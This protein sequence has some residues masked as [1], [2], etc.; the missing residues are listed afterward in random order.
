MIEGTKLGRYEIRAKIGAGGMGEVY[1]AQDTKLD[2]KVALKILPADVAAQPDRMKRFVQEAKAASALNHPNIITIHEIDEWGSSATIREGVHFI[3]TEFID[4]ETLRERMRNAP[5]KLAEVLDVAAQIASALSAA[6]A[7]G[8]VH[9]DIKPENVML[10]RDGIVKVL[11]FGLAKLTEPVPPEAVDT[12]AP[13]RTAIKTES[14][15]VM[16]TAIYM[17]PEQAR[18]LQLDARTD[19]FSLGVLIYEMVAGRLPFE[20]SNTNEIVASILCDREP[21]PLARYAG[22]VPAELERIV[23]KALR[24]EREERYQSVKDLLLDLRSLQHRLK[25]EAELERSKPPEVDRAAAAINSDKLSAG[26]SIASASPAGVAAQTA[27][28]GESLTTGSTS[29]RRSV[30]IAIAALVIAAAGFAYFFYFGRVTSAIDSIAVLPLANTS[31]DPNTEYLSDG[32]SEAL[33]NSLTELQQLRVVAR[34]TAFRY[35]GKEIDPQAV[36][37]ELSV[38]AVLMGTVRQ[39]GDTLNIQVDL[40]DATTGAQLWGRE[41]ERKVSDVLSVKQA[42]AREVTEKLRLRLSG[43]DEQRLAKRDM[44]NAEAYQFYLRGRYFWNKRT[45]ESIDKAIQEFQQAI[46][47]DPNYAL[48]YVGLADCYLAR[49]IY[50][51]GSSN[52]HLAKAR[53]A[54]DRALEVNDS[55]SEAHTSSAMVYLSQWR[56]REAGEEFKRAISLNPNNPIAHQWFGAYFQCSGRSDDALRELKRAQELDPLSPIITV[57]VALEYLSKHDSNSAIEQCQR[58]IELDPRIHGAHH[59]L[60][61]AYLQQHRYEEAIAEL[62]KA[63]ELSGR[64]SLNLASLGYCY[65]LAG[66]RAEALAIIRELEERYARGQATGLQLATVYAGLGDKDHAFAWLEKDFQQQTS[67]V[68]SV[69][70]WI[71]FEDIRADADSRHFIAMEFVDGVTLRNKI[72]GEHAELRKLLRFLQH[73]AEGLAKAHAAGIVHRDLKPDNIMIT[74]D[75]HAKILDFGLAKLIERPPMSGADSSEVA[76][77]VM[78]QHSTPGAIMGTVGYM[79]PEQAQGKTNAI[80]QRSDIFSFVCILFEAATGQKPF[81]GDSVVKSLHMVIYESAP[82]IADLNPSAPAELQRIVRR[83]LAKDPDERYQ[84]IKEVAIELKAAARV[85]KQCRN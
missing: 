71:R 26:T 20:G 74:R 69:V 73:T 76:T 17:S 3:A 57:G 54:A 84:S 34:S 27:T 19:I 61:F 79:S 70:W 22:N 1:L 64:L 18:G 42:I 75:G 35:K 55:L 12:E 56:L 13:T 15:V 16:G 41:Y 44:T 58:V 36:G 78:P 59:N 67:G 50:A 85:G 63:V 52:E 72:Y 23:S 2:R 68:L 10:R 5:M 11:D 32:I 53:A 21:P 39:T 25:F 77:A 65:A 4:G 51:V 33:I 82:P 60:G 66:K 29:H 8:I 14:G 47:H 31:N 46:D 30:T 48:G 81:A 49:E 80:D 83:C 28:G 7:A 6:H 45:A 9:R 38:R 37:R 24:K 40:V 43:E 62:Q